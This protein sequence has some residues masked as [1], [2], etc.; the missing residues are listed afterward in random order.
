MTIPSTRRSALRLTMA[1]FGDAE[2]DD[3]AVMV[4][5][6]FDAQAPWILVGTPPYDAVLLARG[7]RNG[8]AANVSVLRVA[9]EVSATRPP[10]EQRQLPLLLPRPIQ[11]QTLRLALEAAIA[12]LQASGLDPRGDY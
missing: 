12:R 7:T 9:S 8:D 2:A 5:V 10:S 6:V 1:G 11:E 4:R 3:I